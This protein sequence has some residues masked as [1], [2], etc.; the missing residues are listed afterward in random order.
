LFAQAKLN[1]PSQ[2]VDE[3]MIAQKTNS[4]KFLAK[5]LPKENLLICITLMVIPVDK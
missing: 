3:M 2:S 1:S 4:N 5:K